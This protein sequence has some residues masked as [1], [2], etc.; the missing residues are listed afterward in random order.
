MDNRWRF[1]YCMGKEMWGRMRGAGA[2][3]GEPGTSAAGAM[4]AKP[5]R[6]AEGVKWTERE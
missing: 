2:G 1:L 3:K 4:Q 6:E 5:H